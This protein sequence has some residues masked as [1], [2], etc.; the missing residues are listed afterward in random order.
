MPVM[1]G[2]IGTSL[3]PLHM[4]SQVIGAREAAL[5]VTALERLA[6]RVLSE[7]TSQFIRS[8]ESPLAAFP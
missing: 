8:R 7:M 5:A 2:K 4:K 3:M 6:P 1:V